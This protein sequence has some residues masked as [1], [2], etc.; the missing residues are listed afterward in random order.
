MMA[1]ARTPAVDMAAE[2]A[3]A[4][5]AHGFTPDHLVRLGRF[6][7]EDGGDGTGVPVV[8]E[9]TALA[10]GLGIALRNQWQPRLRQRPSVLTRWLDRIRAVVARGYPSLVKPRNEFTLLAEELKQVVRADDRKREKT[11]RLWPWCVLDDLASELPPA[12]VANA[13]DAWYALVAELIGTR[14]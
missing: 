8:D 9:S 2:L 6:G 10:A 4:C 14:A 1:A 7:R 13:I 5:R 11:P 3:L 12:D